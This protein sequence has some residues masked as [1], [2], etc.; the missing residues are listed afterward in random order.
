MTWDEMQRKMHAMG[1][2]G[3]TKVYFFDK[4]G[5]AEELWLVTDIARDDAGVI[6]TSAEID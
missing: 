2:P 4:E 5:A 6:L 3:N 1:F